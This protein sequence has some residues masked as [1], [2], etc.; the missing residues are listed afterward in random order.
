MVVSAVDNKSPFQKRLVILQPAYI[1]WIGFF[2]LMCKADIFVIFD[3]VQYTIRDWRSRNRIKTSEGVLWLSIPVKAKG[4]RNKLIKDVEIDNTQPWQQKHLKS[5]ESFYKKAQYYEEILDLFSDIYQKKY[6]FLID[7]D[8][9]FI[10]KAKH[11][12]SLKS[13]IVLSSEIPSVGNRDE[14][15]LS[16]CKYLNAT[17][18]LSGNAAK[19]YLREQIFTHEGI[20]VQWHDYRHP[21]YHQCWLKEQGFISHLSIIDLLFNYSHDSLSILTG[22][23][24]IPKPEGIRFRNAN[25]V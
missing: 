24:V 13:N 3:D 17:H 6:E 19:E 5:L 8:M 12:L 9:D 25:E 2:D 14:K 1:P 10:T 7:V 20:M 18:Y 15:L 21:Y 23:K 16:I 4:V 11:Y 22:Q